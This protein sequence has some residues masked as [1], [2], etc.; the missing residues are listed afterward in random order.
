MKNFEILL[1]IIIL[2]LPLAAQIPKPPAPPTASINAKT[3]IARGTIIARVTTD[4]GQPLDDV[5]VWLLP[6]FYSE[7]VYSYSPP[8]RATRHKDNSHRFE[9]VR[10]GLYRIS[11][12][13]PGYVA[14]A[15]DAANAPPIY[16]RVGETAQ[17]TMMRGGVITGAVTDADGTPMIEARVR[18]IRVRDKQNQR[19]SRNSSNND[20]AFSGSDFATDDRGVYRIFGLP[21]GAY[22]IV[23]G[24]KERNYYF[25]GQVDPTGG[26]P[27]YHPSDPI[28]TATE[29]TVGYG[30]E[31]SGIN[32]RYRNDLGQTISG[33]IKG[34]VKTN[35]RYGDGVSVSLVRKGSGLTEATAYVREE[36]GKFVFKLEQISSG[37]YELQA[38]QSSDKERVVAS[39]PISFKITDADLTGLEINLQP[40]ASFSGKVIFAPDSA[41][42]NKLECKLKRDFLLPETELRLQR[43]GDNQDAP[44][45]NLFGSSQNVGR[46]PDE[47]G[48]FA[49]RGMEAGKYRFA[50]RL[51][52][53]N[54][55]V[56][57]LMSSDGKTNFGKDG[58]NLSAGNNQSGA[59][60]TI[61]DGAANLSG[62]IEFSKEQINSK[63]TVGKPIVYLIPVDNSDEKKATNDLLRYAEVV[64]KTDG[65]FEFK[66]LAPGK[67][68]LFAETVAEDKEKVTD[69]RRPAVWDTNKL[70]QL[71]TAARNK[72][73]LVELAPCQNFTA[74]SITV[75]Q[76]K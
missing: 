56:R 59:I 23:I 25:D 20:F 54:L 48:D 61:S 13:A 21:P 65:N 18:A 49:F 14:A 26:A 9:N 28:D 33:I 63:Q 74:Q 62:K 42:K 17:I 35:N 6:A 29:I 60:L 39:K 40:L 36:A 51:P 19:L 41:L 73:N 57:S 32:V 68:F 2:S 15:N 64:A 43:E 22:L 44:E 71:Q 46:A 69:F 47:N 37:E 30:Q 12:S 34:A 4:D 67:Y 76:L 38:A 50:W 31:I 27:T 8:E 70:L 53:D 7:S 66:N 10:T 3:E 55:F 58:L 72:N 1:W 75:D 45:A 11:A 16:Y 5:D 24:S 52:S